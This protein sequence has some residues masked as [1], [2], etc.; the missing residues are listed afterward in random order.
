MKICLVGGLMYASHGLSVIFLVF[1]E[2]RYISVLIEVEQ[3]QQ[4]SPLDHTAK[5]GTQCIQ[6]HY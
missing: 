6:E 5:Y 3:K 4:S 1:R 2:N